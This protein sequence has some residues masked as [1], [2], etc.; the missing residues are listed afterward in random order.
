MKYFRTYIVRALTVLLLLLNAAES[1]GQKSYSAPKRIS[2]NDLVGSSDFEKLS[3]LPEGF[4]AA[5]DSYEFVGDNLVARGNAVIQSPGT[6]VS[7]DKIV[8]NLDS[9][10]YDFEAAGNVKVAC[11]LFLLEISQNIRKAIIKCNTG[12]LDNHI[13]QPASLLNF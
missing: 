4:D 10:L 9:E 12:R 5:A 3:K 8:I 11:E 7:A 1:F 6:E 2:A 13:L